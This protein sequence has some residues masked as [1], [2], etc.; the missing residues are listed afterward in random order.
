MLETVYMFGDAIFPASGN[1]FVTG[2]DIDEFHTYRFESLDGINYRI[3]VDGL[4]F[5]V[6]ADDNGN[7]LHRLQFSGSGG[8]SIDLLPTYNGLLNRICG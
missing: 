3:A 5:I 8:C 4:V 7:D 2:L 6:D 1:H